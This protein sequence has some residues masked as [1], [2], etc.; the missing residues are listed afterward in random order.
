MGQGP[1]CSGGGRGLGPPTGSEG[2]AVPTGSGS[3]PLFSNTVLHEYT[4]TNAESVTAAVAD[5]I[6]KGEELVAGVVGAAVPHTWD[7]TLAPLDRIGAVMVR[8]Y[9]V[10]P[11]M[12][13]AHPDRGV[14][15]AAQA[16]EETLS[17]WQSDLVFRRDL[18]EAI[19]SYAATK[20]AATLPPERQ[21]FLEFIR[22]DFRRAGHALTDEARDE[23]QRHRTRLV[24]LEVA[25]NK[26]ID[27]FQDGL[28]LTREQL[29]GVPDDAIARL[30]PGAAPDTFRVSL[31]YPDYYPFMDQ[32]HDRELR[33]TLQFKF[34]NKAVDSNR[35]LLAEAITLRQRI[36]AL[37]GMPSWAHYAMEL[38]MAKEP[39]AVEEL[40]A[41]IVPGL[42]KKAGEELADLR[43]ALGGGELRAWDHRYLHTKIRKD[44]FGV[45]PSEVAAYFPLEQVLDGMFAITGEVLGLKY[46]KHDKVAA[47]HADVVAYDILDAED[48]THL[49]TFY[50]DLFPREGKFGHAAA[51]DLVPAHATPAGYSLPVTAILC[52]FTKPAADGPSLLRHDEVTTLFHEFGHVLHNSLGHTELV[53]FS[54]Y[55]TEWDFVEAPS[56]IM[57]H[58]CWNADVLRR[59]A[60]HHKTGA[61]IPD[62]LVEQLV[63][64]RDLHIALAMLRQVSFGMLDMTFHGEGGE[65]DLAAITKETT[66]VAGFPHH[67]G[68]FYPASFGHLFGYDAGYYGYLWAKVFGDDMFSR[69][70]AEG[71]LSPTVGADYR[72]KVLEPGGSRD[73]MDLL[74]DF[75]GRDPDQRAFLRL[76]GIS[77]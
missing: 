31:D 52:N 11:F 2:I 16:G 55:N 17:K 29:A 7:N 9:G 23:V 36:G 75:L 19:E 5:A 12:G 43:T 25:F 35:P 24:E 30:S 71:V 51:F 49:A 13:R 39:K 72:S 38:K 73:P 28:D 67:E 76:L 18:Y 15:E 56:Q 32:A 41:G 6:S 77:R 66:E 10:G 42:T 45:D 14:R 20:E 22:R 63:A 8:A 58:W 53:R 60:R 40:Y 61:P 64:A 59:F 27:E 46:R 65:K 48:D 37:F 57:E 68:T 44:R 50:M 26:N 33:E 62:E 47:W 3:C 54:G 1:P 34:F 21:R 4:K 69:F 70:E 74:K